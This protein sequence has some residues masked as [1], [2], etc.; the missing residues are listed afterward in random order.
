M[1]FSLALVWGR[2]GLVLPEN[3][4]PSSVRLASA[5]VVTAAGFFYPH[6]TEGATGVVFFAPLGTIPAPALILALAAL[7]ATGRSYSI[8]AAAGTW[9]VGGVFG[10]AG[11]FFLGARADWILVAAVPVSIIAYFA[12]KRPQTRGGRRFKRK[13]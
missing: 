5:G 12:V 2:E 13:R 3:F 11:V 10:L 9:A 1:L 7:V 8:Y 4:R 6:F